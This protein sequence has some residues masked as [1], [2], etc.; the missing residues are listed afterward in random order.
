MTDSEVVLWYYSLIIWHDIAAPIA[1]PQAPLSIV[2]L[3]RL[4]AQEHPRY[5]EARL[6]ECKLLPEPIARRT[7][8]QEG[9]RSAG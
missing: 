4:A 7:S 5:V 1:M 6:L 2:E 8:L 3:A 9:I